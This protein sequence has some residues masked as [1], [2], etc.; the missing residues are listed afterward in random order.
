[1]QQDLQAVLFDLDGPLLDPRRKLSVLVVIFFRDISDFVQDL[2][3]FR[4]VIC[5]SFTFPQDGEQ[6]GT[7]RG[8]TSRPVHCQNPLAYKNCNARSLKQDSLVF[9]WWLRPMRAHLNPFLL[10]VIFCRLDQSTP[11]ACDRISCDTRRLSSI[12]FF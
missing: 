3:N 6:S 1:M 8:G 5:G 9:A 4:G 10:L 11:T 7:G 2:I 12:T